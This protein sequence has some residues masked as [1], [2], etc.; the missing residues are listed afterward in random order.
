MVKVLTTKSY[1]DFNSIIN[2]FVAFDAMNSAILLKSSA[3]GVA[4]LEF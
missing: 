3:R 2:I 4:G 1:L